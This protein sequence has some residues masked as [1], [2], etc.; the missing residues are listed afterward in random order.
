MTALGVCVG[1]GSFW[2]FPS[3]VFKNGGGAFLVPYLIAMT[4]MGVPLYYMETA[5]GQM[6]RTSIPFSFK[7]I[8]P[9]LKVIGLGI[10]TT[11]ITF[12]SVYNIL[13]TYCYRF[14][15]VSF[16]SPLPFAHEKITENTYFREEIL[17]QSDSIS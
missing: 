17:H 13:L 5:V 9:A 11:T 14:L 4:V 1:Y 2:R 6:H 15:F 10:L 8:H 7:H 12:G 3:L 16:E